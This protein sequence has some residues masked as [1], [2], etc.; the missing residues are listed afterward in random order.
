MEI[1]SI[2]A[3]NW[4]MANE[5]VLEFMA[6][7]HRESMEIF[8]RIANVLAVRIS[9]RMATPQGRIPGDDPASRA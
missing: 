2:P 8:G 1:T 3:R 4:R 6:R 9:L 7:L 5:N